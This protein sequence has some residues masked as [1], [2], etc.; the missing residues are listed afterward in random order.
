MNRW[1]N[2]ASAAHG[3]KGE[4]NGNKCNCRTIRLKLL[5][6]WCVDQS[7][8]DLGAVLPLTLSPTLGLA[9]NQITDR[10][11]VL[12]LT[13]TLTLSLTLGPGTNPITDL[14]VVLPL[15]LSPTVSLGTNQITDLGAVLALQFNELS[16]CLG[17]LGKLSAS[18]RVLLAHLV[19]QLLQRISARSQRPGSIII[20]NRASVD[21]RRHSWTSADPW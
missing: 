1:K 2:A 14:G 8:A 4:R 3:H 7:V 16:H 18:D 11:A 6:V 12:A 5:T 9:T 20:S 19:S 17:V 21:I 15:T 10:G 13:L